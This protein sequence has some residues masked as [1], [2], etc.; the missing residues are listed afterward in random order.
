MYLYIY[1]YIILKIYEH[2]MNI[3]IFFKWLRGS[4]LAADVAATAG[5]FDPPSTCLEDLQE[6]PR[7]E[8]MGHEG[9][10]VGGLQRSPLYQKR[11]PERNLVKCPQVPFQ[12]WLKAFRMWMASKDCFFGWASVEFVG[13]MIWI[14][15]DTHTVAQ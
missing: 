8:A 14:Q 6:L 10:L 11:D 3:D 4:S 5:L 9:H 12:T 15:C 7:R 13:L 2:I 1:I